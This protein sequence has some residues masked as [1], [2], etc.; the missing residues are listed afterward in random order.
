LGSL[1]VFGNQLVKRGAC[2][3]FGNG[4]ERFLTG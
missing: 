3:L 2:L 1:V 4:H